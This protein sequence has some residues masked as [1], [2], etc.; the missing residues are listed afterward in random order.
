MG[1]NLFYLFDIGFLLIVTLTFFFILY[2][3]FNYEWFKIKISI[4]TL[5]K[6]L[7]VDVQKPFRET[8][9]YCI[10]S[11]KMLRLNLNDRLSLPP[12][13]Q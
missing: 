8:K 2:D 7:L 6:Y 4:S 5:N 1:K 13:P 9:T 10:E 11:V 12:Q 3:K